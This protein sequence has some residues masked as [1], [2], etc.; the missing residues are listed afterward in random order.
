MAGD[1]T[2]LYHLFGNNEDL[3]IRD[4]LSVSIMQH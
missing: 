1:S 4:R 3:Q 2:E